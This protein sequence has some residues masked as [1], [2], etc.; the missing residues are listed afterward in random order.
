MRAGSPRYE[1][2]TV[3]R[4]LHARACSGR[5]ATPRRQY[6]R[7]SDTARARRSVSARSLSHKAKCPSVWPAVLIARRLIV[8]E[9][10]VQLVTELQSEC[11]GFIELLK[12]RFGGGGLPAGDDAAYEQLADDLGQ[13]PPASCCA[14]TTDLLENVRH[15]GG[16]K[17]LRGP[18]EEC[19]DPAPWALT[20]LLLDLARLDWIELSVTLKAN[21]TI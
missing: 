13:A 10:C 14:A 2:D 3:L 4:A 21:T 7:L 18:D 12:S 6:D 11:A 5:S 8:A 9:T 15:T 17:L 20:F 1:G 16:V 19:V